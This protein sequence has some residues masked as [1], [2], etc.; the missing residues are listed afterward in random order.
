M[1]KQPQKPTTTNQETN[2]TQNPNLNQ[3]FFNTLSDFSN[4]KTAQKKEATFFSKTPDNPFFKPSPRSQFPPSVQ[5]QSRRNNFSPKVALPKIENKT[6]LPENLQESVYPI[7]A[8]LVNNFKVHKNP[9]GNAIQKVDTPTPQ[10]YKTFN[11]FKAMTLNGLHQHANAQADWH[12]SPHL[13]ATERDQIRKILSFTREKNIR[14]NCGSFNFNELKT[15]LTIAGGNDAAV[16]DPLR[17]YANTSATSD[18]FR[19]SQVTN[20]ADGLLVGKKLKILF[21]GFPSFILKT[22]MYEEPFQKLTTTAE[23]QK[24]VDYYK[25]AQNTPTFQSD[26]RKLSLND[27][28][29][30]T[31][32]TA[33]K[34]P[35]D[36]DS[37]DLKGNVRNYHRFEQ[38]ALDQ[39]DAN[40]KNTTP[41]NPLTL[42]LHTA[43]DHNGAF[44]RDPTLS[45]VI[46]SS[47]LHVLMIEGKETLAEYQ[48]EIEPIAKKYGKNDK[49]DQ[50]M[51]AGH[52]DAQSIQLGGKIEEDKRKQVPD[53]NNPGTMK[54]NENYGKIKEVSDGI[55]VRDKPIAAKAL[56]DEVLDNMN[57]ATDASKQPHRRILFNACLTNSNSI[58]FAPSGVSE[59][60]ARTAIQGW[61]TSNKNLVDTVLSRAAAKG[62]DLSKVVG[63]VASHGRLKML[64]AGDNLELISSYDPYLTAANK[65]DYV[66]HGKEPLG[67]LRAVHEIWA[68]ATASD[69]T[70]LLSE[71]TAR[72]GKGSTDWRN[73]IIE[74]IFKILIVASNWKDP[75]LI[76]AM[77]WVAS[78]IDHCKSEANCR[79][80]NLEETIEIVIN[81]TPVTSAHIVS[82]FKALAT[83]AEW[84][85][86]DFIPLVYYQV[87]MATNPADTSLAGKLTNHINTKYANIK[88]LRDYIDK[89]YMK[90]KG[91]FK[92]ILKNK[93]SFGEIKLAL[94]GALARDADCI[95][96]LKKEL[97]AA[98]EF[99]VTHN[100]DTLLGGV[101][102]NEDVR[103]NM[104]VYTPP[105]AA[106][107]TT[108]PSTAPTTAKDANLT[109]H[110]DAQNTLHVESVTMT[111]GTK[112]GFFAR[113]SPVYKK[114]DA[115]SLKFADLAKGTAII[116][117]GSV[118]EW[119]AIEYTHSGTLTTAFVKKDRV[120]VN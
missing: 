20:V 30:Y 54:T 19:I 76:K 100:I 44:V 104:G 102:T 62:S 4:Q 13:S 43:I 48:K 69:R 70:T 108:A 25:N 45:D 79:V 74:S 75:N 2:R 110:G 96:F 111:G 29:A 58:P 17:L 65:I 93:G 116:I 56:F 115:S 59:A 10:D 21:N 120:N 38:R 35:L 114:P 1:K 98:K 109:I 57:L 73:V 12:V 78:T 50:V 80:P 87:W 84:A 64:D 51:F 24:L 9:S 34:Y 66:K 99:P 18:P 60:Q 97:N 33:S 119:W 3:P 55:N 94:I 27:F 28:G 22:A 16:F 83:S 82:I 41:T 101:A 77:Q 117:V 90:K 92:A 15:H 72:S 107:A 42:I 31:L 46:V 36:Y 89:D 118:G 52:G 49:I 63:S 71:V 113:V 11:E 6:G 81:K 86:R 53:P 40:F 37:T 14:A 7:A 112:K 106:P 23:V 32:L 5:R 103:E 95:S 61:L 8:P 105:S 47:N 26:N 85:A 39:L 91:L 67:V 88:T 68:S